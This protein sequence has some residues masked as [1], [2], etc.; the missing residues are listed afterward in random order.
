[1]DTFQNQYGGVI[2]PLWDNAV[3]AFVQ[4]SSHL[5]QV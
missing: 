2:P 4:S 1:M 5:S 3:D